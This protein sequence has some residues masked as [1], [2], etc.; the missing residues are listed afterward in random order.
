MTSII[1]ITF[2]N[3]EVKKAFL[4]IDKNNYKLSDII[5]D[6]LIKKYEEIKN[7]SGNF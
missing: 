1:T 7:N 5:A 2:K 4:E 3:H 6:I